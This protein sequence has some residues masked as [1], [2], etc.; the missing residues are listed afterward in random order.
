MIPKVLVQ[1]Y[2]FIIYFLYASEYS[3][4]TPFLLSSLSTGSWPTALLT[5]ACC[6]SSAFPNRL[7]NHIPTLFQ[8]CT[9]YMMVICKIITQLKKFPLP[10]WYCTY[11]NITEQGTTPICGDT[12][13]S[14]STAQSV[15]QDYSICNY[16]QQIHSTLHHVGLSEYTLCCLTMT[17]LPNDVVLTIYP[18]H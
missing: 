9:A 18:C 11:R 10:S 4:D 14:K 15:L 1:N 8:Q 12:G 13:V 16:V 2:P 17:K 3:L 7:V 6:P 5:Q